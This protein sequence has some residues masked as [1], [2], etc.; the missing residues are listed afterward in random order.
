MYLV[1]LVVGV[2]LL[3]KANA[4]KCFEC[5]PGTSETCIDTAKECPSPNNLC[6]AMRLVTYAGA[7]KDKEIKAKMCAL[8]GDCI[9][10]SVNF[11]SDKTVIVSECC[12]SELCNI[13]HASEPNF[14][15]NGKKCFSC[16]GNQ[17]MKTLNCEGDQDYCITS[18]SSGLT[19]T[20]SREHLKSPLSV[21]PVLPSS[22]DWH[23]GPPVYWWCS[24]FEGGGHGWYWLI[25]G[26]F[27]AGPGSG[28]PPG[29]GAAVGPR[30][31]GAHG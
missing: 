16:E 12:S 25:P 7:S 14:V 2:L 20:V 3:S 9:R 15:P 11:G 24:L 13:Q 19:A 8:R 27:F 23:F 4:L 30:V 18:T 5:V 22:T 17:C 10:G 1:T 29:G 31:P 6:A 21:E 28:L 26:G